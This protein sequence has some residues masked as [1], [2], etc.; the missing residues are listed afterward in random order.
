MREKQKTRVAI[1]TRSLE[2]GGAEIQ[3]S[4]LARN[5]D[6]DRFELIVISLYERGALV[7]ELESAGISVIGLGKRGRW[8]LVGPY[9]HLVEILRSFNPE[10][11]HSF[12]GPP[13][14]LAAL[15]KPRLD[16]CRLVWGFR[17]SNMD[18]ARYDWSH[19]V[20]EILQKILS[21]RPDRIVVNSHA[22]RKFSTSHGFPATLQTV[23]PNGID[24]EKFTRDHDAGQSIRDDGGIPPASPLIGII[25]RLDPMKDHHTVLR[26]ASLALAS[27]PGLRFVCVGD[28]PPYVR[29]TLQNFA[30]SLGL[31]ASVTWTGLRRDLPTIYSALDIATLTSAFGEGFPNA[32]GEAMSCQVPCAVT[33]VGDAAVVVGDTGIAVPPSQPDAM[34]AAWQSLT[35][36]PKD[37]RQARAE[38]S[39]ARIVEH[40]SVSAMIQA[41]ADLY[42]ELASKPERSH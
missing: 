40:F 16:H 5:L 10:I 18:L 8:D 13:N 21:R 39:R 29:E 34:A 36:E 31:D 33:D 6:L 35:T 12:L 42:L 2:V 24:T 26:A 7:E 19:R 28:G 27:N 3:L 11:V 32:V 22:G 25:A 30:S 41:H 38:K 23:I 14:I 15:A 37:Q 1:L 17:A 20:T 4:L 9:R